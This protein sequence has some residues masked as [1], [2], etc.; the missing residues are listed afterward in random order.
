MRK[1]IATLAL[2]L[3]VASPA[4]AHHGAKKPAVVKNV[5]AEG[6]KPAAEKPAEGAKT[7]KKAPKKT[8]DKKA[9]ENPAEK[10]AEAAPAK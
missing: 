5:V 7:T 2:G 1:T 9:A 10:P 6:D 8:T 4:F 3:L